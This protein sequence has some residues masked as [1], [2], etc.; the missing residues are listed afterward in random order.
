M[1]SGKTTT[2]VARIAWRVAIG[3]DPTGICAVT[4]NRRAAVEL[5]E[6]LD[7]ALEP[8]GVPTGTVAV[9][10]F[11][12]L[13]MRI[14]RSAGVDV[15]RLADRAA[16]ITRLAGG[17]L[18]PAT[19]RL[20][21]DAFSRLTLD[22]ARGPGPERTDLH[23]A[24]AAYR[25]ALTTDGAID[26]DDLVAG[27]V[28]RLRDDPAL[29]R[30][31]QQRA[32]VLLV[33]ESQ[34][35]DQAQLDLVLL[36]T[37]ETRDVFLVGDDDQTI[38]A[39]RLADVRRILGLAA[40][41][42]GMRRVDLT[43][44]YRC[45]PEVVRRADR[46]VSCV[47][48]RF[49]KRIDP[50][51]AADGTLLLV[52]DPGDDVARARRLLD[53]WV[54]RE[55]GGYAILART[56]RQ[57]APYAAVAIE[58]GVAIDI[59]REVLTLDHPVIDR[60]LA[61]AA[62]VE[63]SAPL[64]LRVARAVA[65]ASTV[66]ETGTAGTGGTAVDAGTTVDAGAAPDGATAD[67]DDRIARSVLAWAACHETLEE[68]RDAI[69]AT[70]AARASPTDG[71]GAPEPVATARE[72]GRTARSLILATAHG[73]K[74]LE[75]DH[76][77]VVGMDEGSFPSDRSIDEADDPVRALDE[78]RRLAYVAWT[79]ARRELLLVHDPYAPSVFLREAFD[80]A[81]L[82]PPAA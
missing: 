53:R 5:R 13:G 4:F 16:I 42:P 61:L 62:E 11:H 36:L 12:A 2:L 20:L 37:G 74:G 82:W 3:A 18:P 25:S 15:S 66:A 76:V 32:R 50:A 35:L 55:P 47:T 39:W 67:A 30:Q 43:V 41:L 33:D 7:A 59:A 46:L 17:T 9:R 79:R 48:E 78:E 38:Y 29:L 45:P 54:G 71:D 51:P 22:P 70:R 63:P 44:N 26:M 31:W 34:D 77:A 8:L 14:L 1:T 49:V 27:A 68:L 80:P 65:V 21:D 28:Q 10:T 57:L 52:P 73:T 64:L 24:Y 69:G 6:R 19:M 75:F 56:N 72:P 60:V 40:L 23:A 81:E 58:H